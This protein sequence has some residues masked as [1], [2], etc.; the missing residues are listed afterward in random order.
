MAG[1]RRERVLAELQVAD[2][3]GEHLAGDLAGEPVA[4]EVKERE[5]REPP[6]HA[7]DAAGEPVPGEGQVHERRRQ[8]RDAAGEAVVPEV[9][10]DQRGAH[11][12]GNLAGEGVV[13]EDERPE[14]PDEEQR[15]RY[16]A[17][18]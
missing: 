6:E 11:Q 17:G 2:P 16:P 12:L 15:R 8:R 4:A 3:E 1:A 14:A 7:A 9:E 5:P 10:M 18:E 13:G